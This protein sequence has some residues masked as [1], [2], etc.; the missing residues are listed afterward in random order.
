[1]LGPLRVEVGGDVVRVAQGRQRLLLGA[2]A[3]GGGDAV[4][5]HRLVEAVWGDSAPDRAVATLQVHLSNLRSALRAAGAGDVIVTRSG[6]YALAD[7]EVVDAVRFERQVGE[8][9]AAL[10]AGRIGD[11]ASLLREALSLWRGPVLADLDVDYARPHQARLDELRRVALEERVEAELELGRHLEV[12]GWLPAVARELP[13]QERLQGQL[14]TALYRS[15]RQAEALRACHALRIALADDLGLEPSPALRALERAVLDHDAGLDWVAPAPPA[16]TDLVGRRDELDALAA[17]LRS[18]GI[19]TLVGTGGAGK[20][21]L[22]AEAAPAATVVELSPTR[23]NVLGAIAGALGASEGPGCPLLPATAAAL[24]PLLVLDSCEHVLA[25]VRHVVTEL[26]SL[27]PD[28]TLLLTT[29]ERLGIA[30]EQVIEVGPLDPVSA[31]ELFLARARPLRPSIV[32]SSAVEQ[33]CEV[34]DGLPLALELAAARTGL[35]EPSQLAARLGDTLS[36]LAGGSPAA[37][38]RQRTMRATLAWS[39][40]LLTA[41]E[42]ALFRRLAVLPGA[43]TLDD[44]EAVVGTSAVDALGGL[45]RASLVGVSTIGGT[46]RFRMAVPV[47]QLAAE[48]L[49]AAGEVDEVH[50]R[51]VEVVLGRPADRT[52]ALARAALVWALDSERDPVRGLAVCLHQVDRWFVEGALSEGR[53]WCDRVFPL[54]G[55]SHDVDALHLGAGNLSQAA[56]DLAAATQHF[57]VAATSPDAHLRARGTFG[58]ANLAHLTGADGALE[59]L[60]ASAAMAQALGDDDL[61][62]RCSNG[63][64]VA[65]RR[66]GDH[67]RARVAADDAVRAARRLG[68]RIATV[69]CL[70]NLANLLQAMGRPEDARDRLETALSAA[71]EDGFARGIAAA[72]GS[73][74]ALT[75]DP[76]EA[77]DCFEQSLAVARAAGDRPVMAVTMGNLGVLQ[78]RLGEA[79]AA[80][81]TFEENRALCEQIGDPRGVAFAAQAL[82]ELA[83]SADDPSAASRLVVEALRI[84]SQLGDEERLAECLEVAGLVLAGTAP[85]VAT[86]VLAAASCSR[87]RVG[88]HRDAD[89]ALIW[90]TAR[91][92]A[93]R[94]LG[95]ARFE[96]AWSSGEQL[97][98]TAAAQLV[99]QRS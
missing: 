2:L 56:G 95:E 29:R 60:E 84:R 37:P 73:L 57:E 86:S 42:Q 89:A 62:M 34:L 64:G 53:A 47:R 54:V 6:G 48:Y 41:P 61:L 15:G 81:A 8:G 39:H 58:L 17:A 59:R 18:P 75:T 14:V 79:S 94:S 7:G 27:R 25:E 55:P 85:E 1:M 40:G 28:C 51:L 50:R 11:G 23:G 83:W 38:E 45:V 21:R 93:L 33:V 3:V 72:L 68:D 88:L 98:A 67:E 92:T 77:R 43:W 97:S 49:E 65:A 66:A 78:A 10:R 99:L 76:A 87:D 22:A 26:R 12:A 19:V 36:L 5:V 20:T 82:A 4:P 9:R 35:M 96:A 32:A 46:T 13:H 80:R 63:I 91:A 90:D 16:G 71:R 69:T 44:A 74:A 30:S 52:G 70:V 31:V 24:P